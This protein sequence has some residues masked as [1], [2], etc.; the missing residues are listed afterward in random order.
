MT[1]IL[2]VEDEPG[3][4]LGLEDDFRLEGWDVEL[5][6]VTDLGLEPPA[7][8]PAPQRRP[9]SLIFCDRSGEPFLPQ[10]I[11]AVTHPTI[12][13]LDIFLVP[14]GPGEGGMRYEAVFT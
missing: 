14:I 1:K 4:A 13:R 3:I 9:F 8:A 7:G 5:I 6:A 12:G 10:R 2:V 11:Y